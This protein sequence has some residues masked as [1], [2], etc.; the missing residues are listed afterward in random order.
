MIEDETFEHDL[1]NYTDI[2]EPKIL[3]YRNN[4]QQLYFYETLNHIHNL[5]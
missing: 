1:I 4:N 2:T 5:L 3:F